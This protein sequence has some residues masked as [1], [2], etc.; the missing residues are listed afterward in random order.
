MS[1]LI[2]YGFVAALITLVMILVLQRIGN[3]LKENLLEKLSESRM[4]Q[5]QA[6][7]EHRNRFDERQI[8]ALKI[9]Q[10]TLQNGV[11]WTRVAT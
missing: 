4:Q 6:F 5:Q 2:I 7:G 11:Y 10:D 3:Q 8:E 9:L 1:P